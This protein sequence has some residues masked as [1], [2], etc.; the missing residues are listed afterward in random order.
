MSELLK[1]QVFYTGGLISKMSRGFMADDYVLQETCGA[2]HNAA[3]L[4][5]WYRFGRYSN[6]VS[7]LPFCAAC[8]ELCEHQGWTAEAIERQLRS[9]GPSPDVIYAIYYL[10]DFFQP[11]PQ[12]WRAEFHRQ[13]PSHE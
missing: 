10:Q 3:G 1:G 12:I 7:L 4:P 5:N 6:L 13:Y 9:Y 8:Q 11:S 2:Y